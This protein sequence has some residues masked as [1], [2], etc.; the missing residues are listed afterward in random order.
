M[1]GI[2]DTFDNLDQIKVEDVAR[3]LKPVPQ[4][5]ALENYISNRIL[6]PQVVPITLL[7][8]KKDSAI[9]R[10]ALRLSSQHPQHKN[11]FLGGSP[12]LNATMRKIIIPRRFLDFVPDLASLVWA[13]VDGLL[14]SRPKEDWFQDL[15]TVVLSSDSDEIIG[16]ILLPQFENLTG[17]IEIKLDN[18][19]FKIKSGDVAV[20]PCLKERCPLDFNLNKGKLLGKQKSIIEV[21]G[22]K[23]GLMIDGR[24]GNVSD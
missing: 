13:F 12:F 18:K 23:V 19:V 21:Y 5:I 11:E 3:W 20:L 8:M 7:D 24:F 17:Y 4:L 6:Y 10:E 2:F 1:A 14:L 16:S 15:W 22:G 9:L